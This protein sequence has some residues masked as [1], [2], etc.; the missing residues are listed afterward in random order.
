MLSVTFLDCCSLSKKVQ[1]DIE[2]VKLF[3]DLESALFR[4]I[5]DIL[6]LSAD[7]HT[8]RKITSRKLSA[9]YVV[10]YRPS[11]SFYSYF[12]HISLQIMKLLTSLTVK[13]TNARGQNYRVSQKKSIHV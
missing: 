12:K 3:Y 6:R 2:G 7:D 9:L 13:H 1:I 5:G 4:W 11:L 10:F 8:K